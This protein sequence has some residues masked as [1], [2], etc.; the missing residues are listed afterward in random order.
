MCSSRIATQLGHVEAVEVEGVELGVAGDAV[1]GPAL[2]VE[3][4][5]TNAITASV[6][7]SAMSLLRPVWIRIAS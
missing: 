1:R 3:H 6:V 7:S 4:S 5:R 2:V